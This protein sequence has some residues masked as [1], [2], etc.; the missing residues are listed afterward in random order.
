MQRIDSLHIHRPDGYAIVSVTEL[1]VEPPALLSAA[2]V[3]PL[4]LGTF[5]RLPTPSFVGVSRGVL[6]IATDQWWN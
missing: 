4:T 3:G 6:V 5:D 2:K 1:D